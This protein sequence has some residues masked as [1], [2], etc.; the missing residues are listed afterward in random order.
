M[1]ARNRNDGR[2]RLETARRKLKQAVRDGD[3]SAQKRL[4]AEI[5]MLL[6]DYE[7]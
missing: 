7:D 6:K 4:E 5:R 3:K 1:G 2:D